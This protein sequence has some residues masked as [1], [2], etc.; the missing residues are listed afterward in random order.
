MLDGR[1]GESVRM[2]ERNLG[3]RRIYLYHFYIIRHRPGSINVKYCSIY[4]SMISKRGTFVEFGPSYHIYVNTQ[5][6]ELC[7]TISTE[8]QNRGIHLSKLIIDL[9]RFA[10]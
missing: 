9:V 10:E 5:S 3:R 2:N 8:V 6:L 7:I 4:F 1:K